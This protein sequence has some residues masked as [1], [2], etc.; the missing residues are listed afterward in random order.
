MTIDSYFCIAIG[1]NP[2]KGKIEMKIKTF[3]FEQIINSYILLIIYD[4]KIKE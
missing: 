2:N 3:F 1:I 4:E